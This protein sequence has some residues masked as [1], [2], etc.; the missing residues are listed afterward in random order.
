VFFFFFLS[1]VKGKQTPWPVDEEKP[2]N[3]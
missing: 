3:A 2:S 1:L